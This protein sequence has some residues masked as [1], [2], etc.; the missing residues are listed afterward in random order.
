MHTY[1]LLILKE[2]YISLGHPPEEGDPP[3]V[4]PAAWPPS[5]GLLYCVGLLAFITEPIYTK[6]PLCGSR[7]T[8]YH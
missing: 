6:T 4:C 2:S 7:I 1:R 8:S 5:S 3:S